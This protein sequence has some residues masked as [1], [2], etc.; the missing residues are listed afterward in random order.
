M[1]D[2]LKLKRNFRNAIEKAKDACEGAGER[3]QDH[4]ADVGKMVE[5]GSGTQ[6]RIEDIALTRYACYLIAQNGAQQLWQHHLRHPPPHSLF[7]RIEIDPHAH[8]RFV[9]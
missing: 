6:R 2:F 3:I 4:F 7:H 9:F 1:D 8:N 5:I